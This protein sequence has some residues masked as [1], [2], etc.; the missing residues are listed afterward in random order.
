MKKIITVLIILVIV[1]AVGYFTATSKIAAFVNWRPIWKSDWEENVRASEQYFQ[2]QSV[3]SESSKIDFS[4]PEGEKKQAEIKKGIL[5]SMIEDEVVKNLAKDL[6][7]GNFNGKV[8]ERISRAIANSGAD[9]GSKDNFYK[10]I[11]LLYGW[12]FEEFKDRVLNPQARREI[13]EEEFLKDG[14]NLEDMIK[15]KKKSARIYVFLDSYEW[16]K[17]ELRIVSGL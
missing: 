7:V 14:K 11:K 15:E 12:E 4:S 1:S 8:E 17:E 9:S 5:E 10:G 16:D 6:G 2:A 13:L 3:T